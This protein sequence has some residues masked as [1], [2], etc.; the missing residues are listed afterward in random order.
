MEQ[1]TQQELSILENLPTIKEK[2]TL[3]F[4]EEIQIMKDLSSQS[5][6]NSSKL[7]LISQLEDTYGK[8]ER[9]IAMEQA[10]EL[11]IVLMFMKDLMEKN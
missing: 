11:D 8:L 1:L 3:E 6:E 10:M 7:T 4:S 9:T 5:I 2:C